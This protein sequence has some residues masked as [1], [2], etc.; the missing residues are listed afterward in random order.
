MKNRCLHVAPIMPTTDIARTKSHYE[1]L[2]FVVDIQ[3]D[4]VMTERDDIEVFFGLNAEHDPL[5]T[6]FCIDVRVTDADARHAEWTAAGVQDL[7][8]LHDTDYGSREFNHIDPD[9]L[10]VFGSR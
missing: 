9:N 2:G 7:K 1:R 3:G 5:K 10:L 4:F 6:A 8:A